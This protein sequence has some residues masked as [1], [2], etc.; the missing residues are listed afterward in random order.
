MGCERV[1]AWLEPVERTDTGTATV[2]TT[3]T[4]VDDAVCSVDDVTATLVTGTGFNNTT[5]ATVAA[6]GGSDLTNN[7][8]GSTIYVHGG[9]VLRNQGAGAIIYAQLGSTVL[10]YTG[11]ATLIYGAGADVGDV[12]LYADVTACND[13]DLDT[14]C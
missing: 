10:N 8:Y 12:E 13:L 14:G 6:C 3:D 1:P 2:D 9:A 5:G 4:A 7:A 11:D